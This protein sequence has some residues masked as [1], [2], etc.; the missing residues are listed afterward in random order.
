MGQ[1]QDPTRASLLLR[2]K[3]GG[4]SREV[5]W[6]EFYRAYAP[7]IA[8]FARRMGVRQDQVD[9]LV[10]DVMKGFFS[11]APEFEYSPARGRFRGYLK[12]CVC[13]KLQ[14]MNRAGRARLPV[15]G[16]ADPAAL[17]EAEQP[18]VEMIWQDVWETQKLRRAVEVVRQRYAVNESRRRTFRAFEMHV[19]LDRPVDQVARELGMSTESVRAAKTRV[20]RAVREAFDSLEEFDD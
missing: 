10:Q 15:K 14:A 16:S 6:T 4:P 3:E 19:Q 18:A 9:D 2:L 8:G 20:S 11:A 7:V 17:P 5:A 13:H 1:V 12:T